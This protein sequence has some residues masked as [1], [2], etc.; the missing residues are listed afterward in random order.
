MVGASSV[1]AEHQHQQE[2]ISVSSVSEPSLLFAK[3]SQVEVGTDEEGFTGSWY[4]ATVIDTPSTPPPVSKKKKTP[5]ASSHGNKY[6]VEYHSLLDDDGATLLRE[7]VNVKFLRPLPPITPPPVSFE[8][9]DFVD[10]LYRDG[11]WTGVITGVLGNSRFVVTFQ[12]PPDEI[13]FGLLE[14]RSH[15]EWIAGNWVGPK[16]QIGAGSS[17]YSAG[18]RVEVSFVREDCGEAWFPATVLEDLCNGSFLVEYHSIGDHDEN[19]LQKVIVDLLHIRPSPPH[20]KEKNFGL[21]EKVDAFYRFGWWAGVITKELAEKR[22]IVYF[23]HTNEDKELSQSE[24]RLHMEWSDGKWVAASKDIQIPSDCLE[25]I[26]LFCNAASNT[27]I[28]ILP[29]NLDTTEDNS[30]QRTSHISTGG[31]QTKHS[32]PRSRKP[33]SYSMASTRKIAKQKNADSDPSHL[34]PFKKLKGNGPD[35][36]NLTACQTDIMSISAPSNINLSGLACPADGSAGNNCSKQD[37]VGDQPSVRTQNCSQ[38]KKHNEQQKVGE[39]GHQTTGVLKRRGRRPK[40]EVR[41]IQLPKG[42]EKGN[43]QV[44][45]A[46]EFDEMGCI[47]KGTDGLVIVGLPCN[48]METPEAKKPHQVQNVKSL[49]SFSDPEAQS[50]GPARHSTKESNLTGVVNTSTRR[51]RG[52]PRKFLRECPDTSVTDEK[53]KKVDN[54]MVVK[55]QVRNE[56]EE[57]TITATGSKKLAIGSKQCKNI[58]SSTMKMPLAEKDKLLDGKGVQTSSKQ[59]EKLPKRG[60]K[61]S[62]NANSKSSIQDSQDASGS[63][64]DGFQPNSMRKEVEMVTDDVPSNISDDQPLSRWIE[65]MHTPTTVDGSRISPTRTVQQSTRTSEKMAEIAK[66]TPSLDSNQGLLLDLNHNLPFVKTFPLWQTI[67]AMEVFCMMPQKPHFSPL[68][69]CKESSREG[70]A[71]G[72]MVTFSSVVKKTT[73]LQFENPRSSIEDSLEA[74]LDLE[75]HGFDVQNVRDRLTG[76]LLIKDRQEVLQDQSKEVKTRIMEHNYEIGRMHEEIEE[77]DNQ[78]RKLQERRALVVSATEVKD[79]E[80]ASLKSR[81]GF[82]DEGMESIKH[83]FEELAAAPW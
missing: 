76:L 77:I 31:N 52:R 3:G 39:L 23:K 83:E 14:L 17:V 66:P 62:G 1:G 9:H 33:S 68:Y 32:T 69:A 8:L 72:C 46:N 16:K 57:P 79:S 48:G 2:E 30:E 55:N 35:I 12:N 53:Q 58:E 18:K 26:G 4:V 56:V 13:E 27:P 6:C 81:V 11:W 82:I 43:A 42:G 64:R 38:E 78:I 44:D 51:K 36:P 5:N 74:L 80:M 70:L 54:K 24:L 28:A 71:I 45:T 60:R 50:N 7:H 75:G 10:A 22:Y 49:L 65:G 47:T 41:S 19:V 20:L 63:K 40:F 29:A 67:E 25:P 59:L 21:L 34:H 61:P 37:E 73:E 15:L